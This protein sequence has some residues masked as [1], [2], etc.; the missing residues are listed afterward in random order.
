VVDYCQD[1]VY[2][3]LDLIMHLTPQVHELH[4]DLAARGL[5]LHFIV[6]DILL[7]QHPEW[8]PTGT[9]TQFNRWLKSISE[10]ATGLI[11]ISQAVA[12]EVM[13][14]LRNNPPC[15]KDS[16]PSVDSFHLGA[17]VENS[18]PSKG[19]PESAPKVLE[20]IKARK[21]FLM[22][23]T[24]E[25]RKGYAQTLGAFELLW[26]KGHDVNLVIVGK[27]GWLVEELTQH[28]TMHAEHGHRLFWLEGI[29]DEYLE[30]L[31]QNSHCLIAA[32]EGEG[33]GL[34][35]IE[36]AQH[37]LPIIARDI[38]VFREVAG[39]H[40]LYFAGKAETD[41]AETLVVWLAQEATGAH[42]NSADMPWLTWE[43][44]AASLLGKLSINSFR[45]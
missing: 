3:A 23:S 10:V 34:P 14:W 20:S 31:Y 26:K 1:D 12:D 5:K 21:T 13:D 7:A 38:P 32:S 19:M 29:S 24:I 36:A 41:L 22:V 40:A 2:L 9:A 30:H 33:F 43:Q 8:W 18:L 28:I 37:H 35:L 16:G 45:K 42:Q 44:S 27:R 11:C 17:D 25:P 6:Y 15:R 4:K 39:V